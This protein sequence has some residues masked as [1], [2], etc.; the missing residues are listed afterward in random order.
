MDDGS[1]PLT[2]TET[3]PLPTSESTVDI[4]TGAVEETTEATTTDVLTTEELTTQRGG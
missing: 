1:T 4:T 3:T 2:M